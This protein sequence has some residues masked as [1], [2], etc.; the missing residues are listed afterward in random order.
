M[1]KRQRREF[2]KITDRGDWASE[3]YHELRDLL[4]KDLGQTDPIIIEAE[5]KK[6]FQ[7]LEVE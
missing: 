6:N 1:Y 7:Q 4:I 5:I 3:R 2:I